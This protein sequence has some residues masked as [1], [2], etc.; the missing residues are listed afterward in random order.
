MTTAEASS[1]SDTTQTPRYGE[2]AIREAQLICF[3]NPRPGRAYEVS[4]ELPEFTCKCP[5]SGYPDFAVLRL[6]YQPGPRVIE[7]K[8]IKLYVNSFRDRSISHEEVANRILD[9]LVSAAR[10]D[11]MELIADFHPR[12]NVHT[13]V[14]VS[15]GSRQPC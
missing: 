15:H 13:V 9:D 6:L 5:F 14:R 2:R 10:P 4:I 11:W 8:S 12:G 3:D 7:L 1:L